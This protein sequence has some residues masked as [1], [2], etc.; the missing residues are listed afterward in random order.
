M[1]WNPFISR[2]IRDEAFEHGSLSR[3]PIPLKETMSY[4]KWLKDAADI[5]RVLHRKHHFDVVHH[6]RSNTFREPGFLYN[7]GVPYV[8]GPMGGTTQVPWQLIDSMAPKAALQHALR[9]VITE[10]QL[11]FSRA[12][13][14]AVM[15][16][17]AVLCQTSI[18]KENL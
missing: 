1:N 13:K 8:W 7:L 4:R 14:S 18:D 10:V 11:K 3:S 17:D 9:N 16:A 2:F 12:V 5:A 15:A 6:L